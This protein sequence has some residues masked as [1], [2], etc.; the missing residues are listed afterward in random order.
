MAIDVMPRK[1][2]DSCDYDDAGEYEEKLCFAC[3]CKIV[4]VERVYYAECDPCENDENCEL[5]E[6]DF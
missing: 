2:N 5:Y 6:S 1:E 4:F 3:D